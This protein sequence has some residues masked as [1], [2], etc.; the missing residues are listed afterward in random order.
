MRTDHSKC[1]KIAVWFS[2]KV[3]IDRVTT[4]TMQHVF[5]ELSSYDIFSGK[6]IRAS[7]V[8]R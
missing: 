8:C 6:F 1:G 4:T 2:K 3:E 5:Y 7:D